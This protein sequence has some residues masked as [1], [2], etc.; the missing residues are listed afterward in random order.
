MAQPGTTPPC[1]F[2]SCRAYH[3][4]H[5]SVGSAAGFGESGREG[6]LGAS[7]A[8]HTAQDRRQPQAQ[9]QRL[10]GDRDGCAPADTEHPQ[11]PEAQAV[12]SGGEQL[13]LDCDEEGEARQPSD[14]QATER[15]QAVLQESALHQTCRLR[16]VGSGAGILTEQI[17]SALAQARQ[18]AAQR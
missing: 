5:R 10:T 15:R 8:A 16:S 11:Q 4:T 1:V 18:A 9:Q 14:Q 6:A 12:V 2:E 17:A 13:E 7:S 3:L